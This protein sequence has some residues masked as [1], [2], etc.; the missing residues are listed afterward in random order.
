MR[1]L[2]VLVASLLSSG[3][4]TTRY[5][6]QAAHGELE[7]MGRARPTSEVLADPDTSERT[8]FLLEESRVI[9]RFAKAAG[10]DSQG[11]YGK[12][13]EL[14]RAQ[15]VWFV[16]ASRPLA[17]E[18]KIWRFPIAGSFPYLGWFEEDEARR[19]VAKLGAEGWDVR[20]RPVRAYSTGGWFPDPIVSTMLS[21]KD[22]AIGELAGV[23]LH[24]LVHANILVKNQAVF[25][26]SVASF[27]GDALT[28]DYLVGRFGEGAR[29]VIQY[30]AEQAVD[31]ERGAR[32]AHAYAELDALYRSKASDA[33]KRAGKER[34]TA[35]LQGDLRLARRPNNAD[36]QAFRTYNAGQDAF[37]ALLTACGHSWPRFLSAVKS[38]PRGLFHEPHEKELDAVIKALTPRCLPAPPHAG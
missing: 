6:A 3:C 19:F 38:T 7:L 16:T 4:F 11:N 10:L 31:Q 13:V 8:A 18:P 35:A 21:T 2:L 34:I 26:E 32:M 23:L 20:M 33:E 24:E 22:D 12:Y 37:A 30:H 14:D 25:N 17:F 29:E 9:L 15:V 5:V 1:A 27:V 36:L 28:A